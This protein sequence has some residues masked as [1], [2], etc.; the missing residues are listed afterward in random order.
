MNTTEL[1]N[2]A[3]ARFNHNS[4]K[5]YLKS[6]YQS[7]LIVADQGGLW[8]ATPEIIGFLTIID[9]SHAVLLDS[10][11]NPVRVDIRQLEI[12]LRETYNTVMEQWHTEFTSLEKMR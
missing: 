7:K 5:A 4:A 3:K 10:Y 8:T 12:K 9:R 1:I 11:E 6:K 2:E